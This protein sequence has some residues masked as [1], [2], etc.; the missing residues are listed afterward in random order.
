MKMT[1]E[2]KD[3]LK[4]NSDLKNE[5]YL[6]KNIYR[7]ISLTYMILGPLPLQGHL[8]F[9]VYLKAEVIFSFGSFLFLG[10]SSFF[11]LFLLLRLSSVL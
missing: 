4:N 9:G 3:Y 11:G 7:Q 2:N 5:E 6:N 8:H 10:S 1:L